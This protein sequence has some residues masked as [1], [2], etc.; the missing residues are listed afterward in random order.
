MNAAAVSSAPKKHGGARPGAG[1][2]RD[3]LKDLRT[4]ALTAQK[5]LRELKDEEEIPKLYK[6]LTAPQKLSALFKLRESAYGTAIAEDKK[7]PVQINVNIRRI[8]S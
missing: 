7:T 5:I 4:G 6:E 2:R 3:P 8:G 1:R